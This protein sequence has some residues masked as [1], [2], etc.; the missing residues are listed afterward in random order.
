MFEIYNF[1]LLCRKEESEGKKHTGKM[2]AKDPIT[3][4]YCAAVKLPA[5]ALPVDNLPKIDIAIPPPPAAAVSVAPASTVSTTASRKFVFSPPANVAS[6]GS[7]SP[8]AVPTVAFTFRPPA[9]DVSVSDKQLSRTASVTDKS[10]R[11]VKTSSN[12]FPKSANKRTQSCMVCQAKMESDD[13][14][15]S[16]CQ[17]KAVS[18][19]AASLKA[20]TVCSPKK[21][22]K[23]FDSNKNNI[24]QPSL[25]SMKFEGFSTN[26][27][28]TWECTTC[29]IRNKQE[30]TSCVACCSS[31]PKPKTPLKEDSP[32]NN[33]SKASAV[34]TTSGFG[35]KFKKPAGTWECE[36]CMVRNK[37]EASSCVACETP[38]PGSKT[39]SELKAEV[40]VDNKLP[41]SESGFGNMFKKASGS[42]NCDECLVTNSADKIKCVACETIKPGATVPDKPETKAPQFS[43]GIPATAVTSNSSNGVSFSFGVNKVDQSET[44]Q[45]SLVLPSSTFNSQ[46]PVPPQTFSFGIPKSEKDSNSG[47][48]SSSTSTKP[49]FQ[50]G[51]TPI[52]TT[53]SEAN[54]KTNI[55]LFGNKSSNASAIK[56]TEVKTP[57]SK[58][59]K[60]KDTKAKKVVTSLDST[61]DN[62]P[63]TKLAAT[64][65]FIPKSES[66]S[67][68][69]ATTAPP[70]FSFG[71]TKVNNQNVSS[72]SIEKKSFAKPPESMNNFMF[73]SKQETQFATSTTNTLSPSPSNN[74]FKFGETKTV[75]SS[76]GNMSI[77]SVSTQP[78]YSTPKATSVF[79]FG[80]NPDKKQV[81][82]AV[83]AKTENVEAT[84]V[85]SAVES[86]PLFNSFSAAANPT[87]AFGNTSTFGSSNFGTKEQLPNPFVPQT[88]TSLFSNQLQ[89]TQST[90]GS[91]F[92]PQNSFQSLAPVENKSAPVFS[93]GSSAPKESAPPTGGFVFNPITEKQPEARFG[94]PAA[95]TNPS[96]QQSFGFNS[97]TNA[98]PNSFNFEPRPFTPGA[99]PFGAASNN[100]APSLFA[101]ID[102]PQQVSTFGE[103][104]NPTSIFGFGAQ[105]QAAQAPAN[106]MFEFGSN[107][108]NI[109]N[110]FIPI[111]LVVSIILRNGTH[112]MI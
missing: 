22:S 108:V 36:A 78:S 28:G 82:F 74:I 62:N 53:L 84:S 104:A 59:D 52:P 60:I 65:P 38:K 102:P 109:T 2:R 110:I 24:L 99:A 13:V 56:S 41:V 92:Q 95:S 81:N 4:D 58:P 77:S 8:V 6:L 67:T 97:T 87:A 71:S 3:E 103:Q 43:F 73:G 54:S 111:K 89:A 85:T 37:T 76:S 32:S 29:L 48:S 40:K 18:S 23:T 93:F 31:K 33:V 34:T 57:E 12:L 101:V 105:P 64:S 75:T 16:A 9:S 49:L 11:E 1:S 55:Q 66:T 51:S 88:T 26:N 79:T 46:A 20:E 100:T 90:P 91:G 25:G 70:L 35:D 96:G 7:V 86:K 50:F 68:E 14:S 107:Q 5:V 44:A 72:T 39:T 45:K 15:C 106:P 10:D 83:T 112:L 80:A 61:S 47:V 19:N 94:F 42:W 30:A 69:K 27:S 17:K 98:A 63:S 21:Q